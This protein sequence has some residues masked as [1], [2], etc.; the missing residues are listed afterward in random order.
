M[1]A[2]G[3]GFSAH[4]AHFPK[5]GILSHIKGNQTPIS[6]LTSFLLGSGQLV[7]TIPN[8]ALNV[9]AGCGNCAGGGL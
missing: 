6:T 8:R 5:I 3:A 9:V 1:Q 2:C 7:L 4:S